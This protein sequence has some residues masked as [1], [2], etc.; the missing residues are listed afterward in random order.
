MNNVYDGT[1]MLTQQTLYRIHDSITPLSKKATKNAAHYFAGVNNNHARNIGHFGKRTYT[2]P[3]SLNKVTEAQADLTHQAP[4]PTIKTLEQAESKIYTIAKT[5]DY[6]IAEIVAL[7]HITGVIDHI[8]MRLK[9]QGKKSVEGDIWKHLAQYIPA[10]TDTIKQYAL[11]MTAAK[12]NVQI[13]RDK[14]IS[15]AKKIAR[16]FGI[17][18]FIKRQNPSTTM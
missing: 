7:L 11:A 10:K 8:R 13:S 1:A 9:Q 3:I 18:K 4:E 6:K 12:T 17:E 2:R 14:N 5:R 16:K 15:S